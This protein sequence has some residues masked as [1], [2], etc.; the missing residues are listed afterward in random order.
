MITTYASVISLFVDE[1]SEVDLVL[2]VSDIYYKNG[3]STGS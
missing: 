1:W 2:L 3:S